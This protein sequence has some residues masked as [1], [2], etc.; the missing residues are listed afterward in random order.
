MNFYL[1]HALSTGARSLRGV[2]WL[3]LL[4]GCF[5]LRVLIPHASV[6]LGA[7]DE[8]L[9]LSNAFLMNHGR[10]IYRDFY[11]NYPPGVFQII[12]A[13]L[14]LDLPAIWTARL[15]AFAVRLATAICAARLARKAAGLPGF[16]AWTGS[17]VL[18][19]QAGLGLTFLAYPLALL[20]GQAALLVWPSPSGRGSRI[21]SAMLLG[22]VSYFR[23]DV[24]VY[25]MAGMC[26]VE[27]ASWALR[28]CSFFAESA[29]EL[30]KL[31]ATIAVTLAV[32]WLPVMIASGVHQ[33]LRDLVLDQARRTMPGRVLPL[34]P[35]FEPLPIA[36]LA[37][38]LPAFLGEPTRLGIV[39]GL[40]GAG[41]GVLAVL[42]SLCAGPLA[43][44]RSRLLALV[45]IF[46]L[47]TLPQAWQRSDFWHV[48]FGVP[49]TAAALVA[50]SPWM[51]RPLLMI[52]LLTWFA[53][54]PAFASM[55]AARR[56]WSER[57]DAHFITPPRRELVKF[58]RTQTRESE[59][60]YLGCASHRRTM[61]SPVDLLYLTRRRNATRYV[62]FDPGTVTSEAG[63]A[64]MIEDLKRS[65]PRLALLD[66]VCAYDEPNA[67]RIPGATI[68]DDYLAQH[69]QRWRDV[70]GLA[71]W[72]SRNGRGSK[73]HD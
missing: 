15:F 14:A 70:G 25:W 71:I 56:A 46:A 48:I 10:I 35:L 33:P 30:G 65:Q 7:Y 60:V 13:V 40:A 72:K 73:T 2:P 52:T 57:D 5:A 6:P 49:A 26:A 51:A 58:V 36:S 8:G 68:L 27:A 55:D 12:R 11:S 37:I 34:P 44:G 67:S 29:A 31:L 42:H 19:L 64:E 1:R 59:S 53:Y 22:L 62:Q 9:V 16:C 32:L 21:A 28:R 66:P 24:F 45:V 61:W 20:C 39:L 17:T 63:Q 18:V 41:A 23:H 43:R 4:V 50:A 69:Y 3:P 38:R 54:P 47:A